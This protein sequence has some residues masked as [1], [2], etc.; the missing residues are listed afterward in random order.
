MPVYTQANRPLAIR[1][2]LGEDVLLLTGLRGYE[3][4][5]QPF[6]FQLD[7]LA[8]NESDVPFHRILGQEVTVEMQLADDETRYFSGLVKRF[9]QGDR[10][11]TFVHFRAELVPKLWL[12]T[13][14]VRSRI[15]QHLSVPDILRQVFAGLEVVYKISGSYH[16]RDYCVQYRESDFDFASRLME[17]E[18]IYYFFTHAKDRHQMVVTDASTQHPYVPGERKIVYQEESGGVRRDVRITSWQKTQELRS[19]QYTLWDHCFELPGNHLEASEKTVESVRV[20]KAT[21]KLNVGGEEQLEIYDYPGGYAQRFDGVDALGAP[22]PNDLQR[23]LEDRD[24]TVKVRM[25]QEEVA[26]LEM[27][28]SGDCGHFVAGHQFTLE[29]HFDAD[30][31]YLLTRVEHKAELEG[32]YASGQEPAV[33]YENRFACI[34]VAL[35]YRPRRLTPKPVI[36]GFQTA[37]VVGPPGEE[38]F[39]DRYGRV[40]VQFHW[41]REGKNDANSSCWLRVAQVWAG[42]GWGAFFWPRIGHEVVVAFEEGDPDQPMIVGSVYNAENRPPLPLPAAKMYGGIKSSSLYGKP[43]QN[44]NSVVFVDQKGKEH[45]AIHSERHMVLNAEFDV[46]AEAG[47]HH[48]ERVPGAR[49]I[50]VGRLP[51]T[52]GSGGGPTT[53]D[54]PD[55]S[56]WSQPIPQAIGGLNVYTV[57]GS[58]IQSSI[59]LSFQLATG[60]L[61]QMCVDP[62]GFLQAF[63]EGGEG[64]FASKESAILFGS[65]AGGSL[66]LTLGTSATIAMGLAYDIHI[67]PKKI[68]LDSSGRPAL[69]AAGLVMGTIMGALA[70][71]FQ[72][73]YGLS[74]KDDVRAILAM[75]FEGAIQ[76]LVAGL[77]GYDNLYHAT[78]L[79][80]AYAYN[81]V[82]V[83]KKD[84]E[85]F[86]PEFTTADT[87][88]AVIESLM[89]TLVLQPAV[90]APPILDSIGESKLR[91][92]ENESAW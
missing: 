30:D 5:S 55:N 60:S 46:S 38:I 13:K 57:Y 64:G 80:T 90:I 29:R 28:G 59:P 14:R 79:T 69:R 83:E 65:G 2:P 37:T 76:A 72:L 34:P 22:R 75:T 16:P 24:R 45:L 32:T 89:A 39:C 43:R 71:V 78:E 36:A 26:S 91:Q 3:A 18:G 49:V 33:G 73:A 7:L 84:P 20:G 27:E 54:T 31:S 9:S 15:F 12:L 58:D 40:K 8:E 6:C 25:E 1:T 47:R 51:G 86:K 81:L 35:A 63:S 41:D 4:V 21:H 53:T 44:F 77:M 62:V 56:I 67:G 61:V 70:L 66:Q 92:L 87:I 10:D 74:D 19:V 88:E 11:E 42:K 17:E 23:I 82:H 68:T 85:S 50:T 52:G 48:F